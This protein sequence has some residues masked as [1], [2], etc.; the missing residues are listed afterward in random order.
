MPDQSSYLDYLPP[1]LWDDP[2][3]G[4]FLGR[5]L[6]I[7]EKILTGLDDRL[8]VARVPGPG[9]TNQAVVLDTTAPVDRARFAELHAQAK[10]GRIDPPLEQVIDGLHHLFNPM[11]T[12]PDFLRYLASWV[13][14]EVDPPTIP[15]GAAA[16]ARKQ[17]WD[18]WES[19][20]R[21]LIARIPSIYRDRWL[22]R[23]LYS[24]LELF[25][26][27]PAEPRIVIDDGESLFRI[28]TPDS[29]PARVDVVANARVF[30]PGDRLALPLLVHPSA[31]ASGQVGGQALLVIADEGLAAP[32]DPSQRH[33]AIW[34]LAT[35]GVPLEWGTRSDGSH[36]IPVPRPVN[37]VDF[38]PG[39]PADRIARLCRPLGVAV[40]KDGVVVT[41]DRGDS[42][43]RPAIVRYTP[44]TSGGYTRT[45]L[46][47]PA[48]SVPKAMAL[49]ADAGRLFV[50]DRGVE[51]DL[52]A[53][54]KLRIVDVAATPMTLLGTAQLVLDPTGRSSFEPT[55]LAV[56][57][58]GTLV[59]VDA[60]RQMALDPS[61][62]PTR[63]E[64]ACDLVAVTFNATTPS[65]DLPATSL[66]G[67]RTS[68]PLIPLEKNPLV[69]PCS[70]AV[71]PGASGG[72]KSYAV[73]D[74]GVKWI[75]VAPAGSPS[76]S[77][78][79]YRAVAQRPG[80]F[81]IDLASKTIV[82]LA[83]GARLGA[84]VSLTR[85]ASGALVVAD[86]GFPDEQKGPPTSDARGL[87]HQFE[88]SVLFSAE[89]PT[90]E[91]YQMRILG[92]IDRVI[93]AERPAQTVAQLRLR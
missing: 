2:Q 77:E 68:S 65:A 22:K 55:A 5:F 4:A 29:G 17:I 38:L 59:I 50:L 30:N 60:G 42:A 10:P 64:L 70:V 72:A 41:L 93:Q 81:R 91:L 12:R 23:G 33:P 80:V 27:D 83:P 82:N 18:E 40:N 49:D 89:R 62:D 13:A 61:V 28:T 31:V 45:R 90:T 44:I 92:E 43:T 78:A 8:A 24:Y 67:S 36:P 87:P 86:R 47:L 15:A 63:R 37:E 39:P 85:E 53:I 9:G 7:F 57:R 1:V 3:R 84:P 16:A 52:I 19:R 79:N 75:G 76:G 14:L 48:D 6:R 21:F 73:C 26:A 32:S 74:W 56:D 20:T 34:K 88:V 51:W 11:R 66:L 25:A 71:L 58:P 35:T 69:F 54:P 46:E